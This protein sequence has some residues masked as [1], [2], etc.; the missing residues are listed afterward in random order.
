MSQHAF[1]TGAASG[2]G[3]AIAA[4]LDAAGYEV[5]AVDNRADALESARGRRRIALDVCDRGQVMDTIAGLPPIDLLVNAAGVGLH[6][7]V[8]HC[9]EREIERIFRTN[10]CGPMWTMQAV[11]PGMRERN[12]GTIV[13]LT[14]VAGR[15]PIVLTGVYSS[16]K[17][18]LDVISE[19][20]SYELAGTNIRVII[21]EPGAT[22][23]TFAER[24]QVIRD[25]DG[26][27]Q[28][29]AAWDSWVAKSMA[30]D[31]A[32]SADYVAQVLMDALAKP[33]SQ[34]RYFGSPAVAD[35]EA[36]RAA[37]SS[38]E[39]RRHVLSQLQLG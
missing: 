5:T 39:W 18:G 9:S 2:M 6:G 20:L 28:L 8:E 21:L 36:K 19:V 35:A 26:Y 15:A 1:V 7:P 3:L 38:E 24:R 31:A 32:V 12:A 34:L 23:T 17:M 33:T 10:Y 11:L 25:A 14:S 29:F 22:K 4:Q 13:N 16:L 37:L 30:S 27:D